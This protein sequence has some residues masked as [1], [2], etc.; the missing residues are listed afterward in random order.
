LLA[1]SVFSVTI[2]AAGGIATDGT[3]G[4]PG[5][6]GH[7]QSL[8]GSNV[9]VRESLGS[10]AGNNLFHSFSEFNVNARQTVTFTENTPNTLDNVISRVTG[11]STSDIHGKLQSTPG[12]HANFYLINPNG[13]TFGQG[14]QVDVP[15][16]FHVSTADELKFKDGTRFSA[17][18]PNASTLTS[19]DPVAFGFLGTSAANNG[20]LRVDGAHL[21]VKP[22][23]TFDA[24]AGRIRVENDAALAAPAGQIRL[25]AAQ[26]RSDVSLERT[27]EGTLS[28]P[29]ATP[30]VRNAGEVSV[31]RSDI[32]TSGEG[33]G[34]VAVWGGDVSLKE[35]GIS[36]KNEGSTNAGPSHGVVIKARDLTLSKAFINSTANASGAA[37]AVAVKTAAD[38]EITGGRIN[39][40]T[41]GAGKA[42][43]VTVKS[44]GRLSIK[45][46]GSGAEDVVGIFS[47]AEP[48][49]T[50]DA[51]AV[52]VES[53][54]DM[55]IRSGGL[56]STTTFAAGDAGNVKVTAHGRLTIDG[57]GV[58]QTG[59]T[60]QAD[61]ESTGRAGNVKVISKRDM[62]I[63]RF[64]QI[65]ST[66]KSAGDAGTVTVKSGGNLTIDA[67]G[68]TQSKG[69]DVLTGIVTGAGTKEIRNTGDAGS[70]GVDSKGAVI[71]RNGAEVSSFTFGT[72]KAGQVS[73]N[74]GTLTLDQGEINARSNDAAS[75]GETGNVKI[76][77][78]KW[79]AITNGG[80]ISLENDAEAVNANIRAGRVTVAAPEIRLSRGGQITS[81]SKGNVNAADIRVNFDR[82]L[83]LANQSFIR[84]TAKTGNGGA[85]TVQGGGTIRLGDSGFQTS[86]SGQD[87]DGG[88]IR[89]RAD[90][91]V[92]DTGAIEAN[93]KSGNGGDIRLDLQSLIPSGNALNGRELSSSDPFSKSD[94]LVSRK[95][96]QFGNNV[97]QAVSETGLSGTISLTAPQLN[98][99]G[100]LA[101]LGNPAFDTSIIGQ[102]YCALGT[103]SS[104]TVQ[105]HGGLPPKGSD[106]I[107]Y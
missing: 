59:I 60:A 75:S 50:G 40:S 56:I 78:S 91:L 6:L 102:D 97:I 20:L 107:L 36:A 28:L 83:V 41:R 31:Q 81:Q 84:T 90:T 46:P 72:G 45:G 70:I 23:Q 49:S 88:D 99:S 64:G 69:E 3:V 7:P 10:R 79:V 12:G 9:N 13:V 95:P 73:F 61:R 82:A 2:D 52:T 17:V 48:D 101:N 74:A 105:G 53:E 62:A 77:A 39:S 68:I 57:K 16:A 65:A 26:G 29:N 96:F 14:A 42:G 80:K 94:S 71:L 25:V 47:Q 86:V 58:S 34:R 55:V 103:G 87:G 43:N 38:L 85:I 33:G 24:V 19:A 44:G 27:P 32:T 11:R 21:Q 5:A 15:G 98:L 51:G 104:L 89:V 63:S 30:S 106:L 54:G 76:T 22:G 67:K 8:G 100:V 37:G 4:G 18:D 93:A 92:M 66:T 35:R 1:T